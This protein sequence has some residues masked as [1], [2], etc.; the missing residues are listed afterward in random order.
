MINKIKN[1]VSKLDLKTLLI[2]GLIIALLLTRMCS[3]GDQAS[4]PVVKIDG[5]KYEVVKHTVDTIIVTKTKTEYRPGK[6]IY[7]DLPIYVTPPTQVDS[8]AIVKEYYSKIVYKDTLN[9]NED[10]GTITVTDTV[11]QNKIIG[12]LWS[13]SIKQ[14]TIHDVTIVKELP[15]TQL[16]IGGT[17]GFDEDNIVNFVGPSLLLKTK[18]DR[19]YSLG[20]GYGTDKTISIQAGIYWKIKLGK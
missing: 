7:K 19:V 20:I 4:H 15:K 16:Y 10:G 6:V 1:T 8:L 2:I 14:K 5:K 9:L 18:Q 11:S 3:G 17:A 12:R 13:A